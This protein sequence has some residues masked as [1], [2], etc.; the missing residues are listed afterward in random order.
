MKHAIEALQRERSDTLSTL[1]KHQST[2][3]SSQHS[4]SEHNAEDPWLTE[5]IVEEKMNLAT[6]RESKLLNR[7]LALHGEIGTY[8]QSLMT[9]LQSILSTTILNVKN[10][11]NVV[12][13]SCQLIDNVCGNPRDATESF[14]RF[15]QLNGISE[16]GMF[17]PSKYVPSLDR[18]DPVQLST[19]LSRQG[20]FKK[21]N[22]H[23]S[24]FVLTRYGF[25][26]C[27]T[28]GHM[29]EPI[30][31]YQRADPKMVKYTIN[32]TR[33]RV[34]VERSQVNVNCIE[35]IEPRHK[36]FHTSDQKFLIKCHSELEM[37]EWISAMEQHLMF[38]KRDAPTLTATT[39][40]FVKVDDQ[41]ESAVMESSQTET[42][43]VPIAQNDLKRAEV[44]Q[45][46]VPAEGQDQTLSHTNQNQSFVSEPVDSNRALSV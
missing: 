3:L 22:F 43:H 32:L 33:P 15:L 16:P 6:A 31:D 28:I 1:D 7:L 13:H 8:E 40:S 2:F 37:Q 38:V 44:I 46:F 21:S 23:D 45:S 39:P 27:F 35:I 42:E 34:L 14:P 19:I 18:S 36:L 26:H 24:L 29:D 4:L 10:H 25:L 17:S 20:T 11:H 41:Y 30:A 12:E 5:K 9:T